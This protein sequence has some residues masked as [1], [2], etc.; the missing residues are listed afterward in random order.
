MEP[1]KFNGIASDVKP[2]SENRRGIDACSFITNADSPC[3]KDTSKRK[4]GERKQRRNQKRL[5]KD[6]KRL[7]KDVDRLTTEINTLKNYD[8]DGF[9]IL[10]RRRNR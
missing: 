7:I 2:V 3:R 1:F 8:K 5:S 9:Y 4:K 10:R 6:V